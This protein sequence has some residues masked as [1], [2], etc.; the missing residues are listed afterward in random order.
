MVPGSQAEQRQLPA[1]RAGKC[2]ANRILTS[3]EM[4]GAPV[5][6]AAE[7][8]STSTAESEQGA[9]ELLPTLLLAHVLSGDTGIDLNFCG[10][11]RTAHRG[12]GVQTVTLCSHCDLLT[13]SQVFSLTQWQNCNVHQA[14]HS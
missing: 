11:V 1:E 7:Q 8:T 5:S 4:R 13:M 10:G 2:T 6:G 9:R 3:T 12:T 14:R